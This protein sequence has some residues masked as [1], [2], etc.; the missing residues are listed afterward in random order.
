MNQPA[1][2]Q[3]NGGQLSENESVVTARKPLGLDVKVTVANCLGLAGEAVVTCVIEG[4]CALAAVER[5]VTPP[6]KR[7]LRRWGA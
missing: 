7:W 6:V 2:T 5:K 3:R 4:A 1:E